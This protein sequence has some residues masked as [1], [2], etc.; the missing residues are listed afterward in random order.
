LVSRRGAATMSDY[1]RLP[2]GLRLD[3]GQMVG[4][5]AVIRGLSCEC[6]CPACK[7]RLVA[8]KGEIVRHHF[9][10]YAEDG[11]CSLARETALH[12]MAKQI[13]CER[14]SL[15]LPKAA[16]PVTLG[17]MISA[18][19]EVAIGDIRPDVLAQ[20]IDEPVA[21]EVRVAH[22]VPREKLLKIHV[23]ELAAIEIDL[24]PYRDMELTEE[25]VAGAVLHRAPR[26][27]LYPP[28][29]VR[30]A[31]DSY[32]AT[33]R[34][35]ERIAK[36]EAA[37]LERALALEQAAR[38]EAWLLAEAERKAKQA[39]AEAEAA[40]RARKERQEQ[41]RV[42][43]A[44]EALRAAKARERRGPCLQELVAAYGTYPQITPE[45]WARF[46]AEM[47][48]CKMKVREGYFYE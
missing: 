15:V 31:H 33:L 35:K 10:H 45:A 12:L 1:I 23:M 44:A 39:A 48:I 32:L 8:V 7:A 26:A 37:R 34:A 13:V 22:W 41:A 24:G 9:R 18:Q 43:A 17:D 29:C 21:I 6:V 20:Y 36:D 3:T 25:L 42:A 16:Y 28:Q 14:K 5:D 19:A 2:F 27:W 4:I 40:E 47:D 30:D 38:R 46:D 11:A